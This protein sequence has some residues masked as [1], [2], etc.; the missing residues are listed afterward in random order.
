M[1]LSGLIR[2]VGWFDSVVIVH[3]R[4]YSIFGLWPAFTGLLIIVVMGAIICAI[5]QIIVAVSM[6]SDKVKTVLGR[7]R[8]GTIDVLRTGHSTATEVVRLE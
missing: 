4:K 1:P 6:G 3:Q 5:A 8:T 7:L 2:L